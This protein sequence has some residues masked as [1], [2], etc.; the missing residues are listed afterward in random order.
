MRICVIIAQ[1]YNDPLISSDVLKDIGSTW[2]SWQTWRAWNTDNVICNDKAKARDLI[3]RAFQA[4]CN[5]YIP[6]KFYVDLG[7]PIGVRLYEGEF[8][9]EFDNAED[10]VGMHLVA[11]HHDL[12]LLLGY[13][14]ASADSEDKYKN[15]K[16]KNYISAFASAVKMYNQTQW[17]LVDFDQV[18][19]N[20]SDLENITCD[21]Y[22]NMLHLLS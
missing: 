13:D 22:E 7:R 2:G 20:L 3:T 9:S 10:I 6:K 4:V 14:L 16:N 1:G 18:P 8:P 11:E 15:H 19:D 21:S 5:M 17:V 12:V